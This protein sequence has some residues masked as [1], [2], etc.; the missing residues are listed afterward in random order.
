MTRDDESQVGPMQWQVFR[1]VVGVLVLLAG[2]TVSPA[3]A[4][5][6]FGV[7]TVDYQ[8]GP[9]DVVSITVTG[10]REFNQRARVSNSGRLRIPYVGIMFV[11]DMTRSDLEAEI[12]TRIKEHEL[13]KEPSVRVEIEQHRARPTY[14]IG[15]VAAPGQFMI[16][17]EVFLMDLLSRAGGLLP[18]AAD[19]GTLYRRNSGRPSVQARIFD[20]AALPQEGP[21]EAPAAPVPAPRG[22]EVIDVHFESLGDGSRSDLNVRLRGGEVLYVPRRLEESIYVIG[23]VNIPG[24]YILPRRGEISA[25]Q[26]IVYAGGTLAT[27]SNGD[28]FLMRHDADGNRVEI[29]IDFPEIIAGKKP[30]I[31][32]QKD[33]IIFVPNSAMKTVG[34]GLFNMIPR[35]IQQW[36]IF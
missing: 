34:V 14:V 8:L 15:D 25:A 1:F 3:V 17:G 12:A 29:P 21:S 7:P 2:V 4:G 32:V 9:G 10:L 6:Q 23:D 30:D 11:V 22:E 5:Q 31:P 28:A 27:A 13:V 20:P 16:T 35:I 36:L 19:S 18:S 26:A 33:D 24:S